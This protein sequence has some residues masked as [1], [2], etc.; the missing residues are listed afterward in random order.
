[1]DL[2]ESRRRSLATVR[3]TIRTVERTI[4]ANRSL[5]EEHPERRGT[6]EQ[7]IVDGEAELVE[8]RE[9]E[10]RLVESGP[11]SS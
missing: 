5:A 6:A 11:P 4:A 1:M 8:L 3:R 7:R 10:R 2:D 9:E